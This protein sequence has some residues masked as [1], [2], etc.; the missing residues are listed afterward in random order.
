M[1]WIAIFAALALIPAPASADETAMQ[2]K[3]AHG[4]DAVEGRSCVNRR[5]HC[6]R[7]LQEL[8]QSLH[9]R[10]PVLFACHGFGRTDDVGREAERARIAE[11]KRNAKN[12]R[13]ISGI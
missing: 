1:R 11:E 12:L 2:L 3:Q 9:C 7:P 8:W 4:L 10:A 13:S 6:R 5:P